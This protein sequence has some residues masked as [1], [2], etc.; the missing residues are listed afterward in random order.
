MA[1][2]SIPTILLLRNYNIEGYFTWYLESL[3]VEWILI[4]LSSKFG[5]N[6]IVFSPIPDLLTSPIG[7]P[8]LILVQNNIKLALTAGE[9]KRMTRGWQHQN[10]KAKLCQHPSHP[11]QDTCNRDFQQY[12]LSEA[13]V[14]EPRAPRLYE[15]PEGGSVFDV[16]V[17]CV[18][19]QSPQDS[20][21]PGEMDI[22]AVPVSLCQK[23]C[24]PPDRN[25]IRS[26]HRVCFRSNSP[27]RIR[28]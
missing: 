24:P 10:E 23:C 15:E 26:L 1:R 20:A 28:L 21:D 4:S 14:W 5:N 3:Q 17:P 25:V 7:L 19:R 8:E 22:E 16:P 18:L 12:H 9:V 6:T 11:K 27:K 13:K 2:G